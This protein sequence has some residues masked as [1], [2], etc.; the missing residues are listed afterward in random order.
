MVRAGIRGIVSAGIGLRVLAG[1]LAVRVGGSTLVC[2]RGQKMVASN[3][4]REH[5]DAS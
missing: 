4:E 1:R 3:A 2:N 5:P